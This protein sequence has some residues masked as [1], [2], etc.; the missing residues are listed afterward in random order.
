LTGTYTLLVEGYV[1]NTSPVN[2]SFNYQAIQSLTNTAGLTLGST[3]SGALTQAGQQNFYTFTLANASQLYFDALT[4]DGSFTWS[5]SGPRGAEISLR[6][7]T[8]SD[9]GNF[10]TTPVIALAAGNYTLSIAGSNQHR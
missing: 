5:L 7:F 3:V 8:G 4:N 2:Y 9:A 6:S 1:F 10:G